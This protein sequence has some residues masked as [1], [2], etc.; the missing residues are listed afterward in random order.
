MQPRRACSSEFRKTGAGKW[1]FVLENGQK[2]DWLPGD[3]WGMDWQFNH[4][5]RIP[6]LHFQPRKKWLTINARIRVASEIPG[7]AAL[8]LM[9]LSGWFNL[10]LSAE[11]RQSGV[12]LN[13]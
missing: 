1:R 10:L 9:V 4:S 7:E 3:R 12:S 2:F 11:R 6:V 8:S 5:G 13:P